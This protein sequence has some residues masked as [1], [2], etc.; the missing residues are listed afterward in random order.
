MI[1]SKLLA[2]ELPQ[3]ASRATGGNDVFFW[4][5]IVQKRLHP[6][7]QD[8]NKAVLLEKAIRLSLPIITNTY[9]T[10]RPIGSSFELNNLRLT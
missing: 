8:P 3:S 1:D 6:M 5:D 10:L 9:S 4:G 7:I 2:I